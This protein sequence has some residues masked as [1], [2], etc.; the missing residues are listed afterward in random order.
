MPSARAEGRGSQRPAQRSDIDFA[1]DFGPGVQPDP[2]NR[3]FGLNAALAA[4]F[5]RKVTC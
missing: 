5:G 1:V 2:F 3:C 4:P